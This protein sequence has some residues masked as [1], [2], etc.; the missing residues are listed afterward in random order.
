MNSREQTSVQPRDSSSRRPILAVPGWA[1]A[2]REPKADPVVRAENRTARA[3]G[4]E[5]WFLRPAR[6]FM[7]K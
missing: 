6:Q 5:S 2:A 7:T 1:E 4:D 3:V